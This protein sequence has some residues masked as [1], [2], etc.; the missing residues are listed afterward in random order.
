[1]DEKTTVIG[2][3]ELEEFI[4]GEGTFKTLRKFVFIL[5]WCHN[6]N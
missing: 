6:I 2:K 4:I 3:Q 1:M 5:F